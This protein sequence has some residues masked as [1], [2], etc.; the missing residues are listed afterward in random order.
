[1]KCVHS[2]TVYNAVSQTKHSLS[3]WMS[4][5]NLGHC[6]ACARWQQAVPAAHGTAGPGEVGQA[7]V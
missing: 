3:G 2:T 6:S 5:W 7:E 4:R 1:M